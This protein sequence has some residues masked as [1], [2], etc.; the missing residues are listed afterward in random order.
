MK[1]LKHL[2]AVGYDSMERAHHVRDELVRLGWVQN[3]SRSK[4][5]RTKA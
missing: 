2:W 3:L 5:R 4:T 1:S